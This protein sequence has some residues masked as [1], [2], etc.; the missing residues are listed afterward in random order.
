MISAE[1]NQAIV[2]HILDTTWLGNLLSHSLLARP[3]REEL[4]LTGI[5]LLAR[6]VGR[7]SIR[8]VGTVSSELEAEG[9]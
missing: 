5:R 2:G 4:D 6:L 1:Q 9:N 8:S 7:S 3:M